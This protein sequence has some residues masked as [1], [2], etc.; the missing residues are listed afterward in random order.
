MRT[1][2]SSFKRKIAAVG[3]VAAIV[4]VF[5][6]A[7]MQFSG[8]FK[9]TSPVTL[10]ADRAGL[11]MNSDAKVRLRGVVIGRVASI[12]PEGDHV[13][14]KL[15]MDSE[16]L[17]R[18]PANVTAQIRSNT[19][20]G[21]KSVDLDIPADPSSARLRS[22]GT[23]TADRVQVE[24][25]T[26]F[27]RLVDVL[28]QVQPDK[29]NATLGALDT[30]LSGRGDQIGQGLEDLSNLLARTNPVLG[31]LNRTIDA[32]A[33]VTN[34]YADVFPD[35][36]R[37]IDNVTRTGNTLADNSSNLDA[38]LV[39]TTGLANTV[40][41]II[42]PKKQTLMTALSNFDPVSQLLGYYAPGL[43]CFLK[44]TAGAGKK[45]LPIFGD[46]TG[47]I[48]LNAGVLP[49]KEPYRYPEDLPKVNVSGPPTCA[50]G[51]SDINATTHAPFYVGDTGNLPYQPRTTPKADPRKLFAS[52]FGPAPRG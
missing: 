9:S 27:Q 14:L 34:V 11:V 18:V 30:A 44:A 22:G 29:L 15:N 51:L 35:L 25:N 8:G 10:T 36:S 43:S 31:S 6:L 48:S 7:V 23:I 47:Y 3:M 1:E 19:V 26:V 32:T 28:A 24:L 52:M 5:T 20:F 12:E 4:I 21:A 45:A 46:K 17:D 2:R 16:Q 38:L 41:G 50:L 13:E 37:I 42:A 49:G 39:N 33:T 40:N